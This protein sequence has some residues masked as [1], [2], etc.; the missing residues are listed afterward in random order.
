MTHSNN[1]VI[2]Q[3]TATKVRIEIIFTEGG[4]FMKADSM[5]RE[6]LI[7]AIGPKA[8]QYRI[9][10]AETFGFDESEFAFSESIT[11]EFIQP[12]V[13]TPPKPKAPTT[14]PKARRVKPKAPTLPLGAKRI[15]PKTNARS[16]ILVEK[17]IESPEGRF[18]VSFQ[19]S[20]WW[21]W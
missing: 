14:K 18:K 17:L 20:K 2:F 6:D 8:H 11:A 21:C 5:S 12:S 16:E 10:T 1:F 7:E 3:C 4:A 13:E 15:G 9:E 19:G